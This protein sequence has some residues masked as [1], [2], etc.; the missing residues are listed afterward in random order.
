MTSTLISW[1]GITDMLAANSEEDVGLGPI[2]QAILAGEY[3]RV[4][5]LHDHG[6]SQVAE[7]LAWLEPQSA[8]KVTAHQAPLTRPT[9]YGEIYEAA[10]ALLVGLQAESGSL[11]YS[12]HLSPGTPAMGAVWLLLAKTA[13][14]GTLLESSREGGVLE[15]DVPFDIAADFIPSLLKEPDRHLARLLEGLPPEA[16]EFEQIIHRSE[17]MK[18]VLTK[19]RAVAPR[20]LP[21]LIEGESGTGKELL[22]RAIHYSSQRKDGSFVPVNCGAIPDELAESELFGHE[23]GAFTGAVKTREGA[24]QLANGGTLFLDEIGELPMQT[25]VKLLRVLQEGEIVPVGATLPIKVDV[26]IIAATNR[27]LAEEIHDGRFREDLFYRL[28]GAVLKLPPLRE[29]PGDIGL[30]LDA[31][32]VQVNEESK[33]DPGYHR[34]EL[35]AGARNFAL[36]Q[37]WP[38]NVRELLNTLRRAAVWSGGGTIETEDLR[39]ALLPMGQR[40]ESDILERPLGE[41]LSLQNL[42]EEVAQHYLGRALN[43]SAGNKTKAAELVGLPSYQTFS[44]WLKKYEVEA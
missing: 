13:F 35:S 42:L 11:V 22:S 33:E 34:K 21:V 25:Q 10:H 5:L 2:A 4:E 14:P 39:E 43:E 30:L 9:A 24:F 23:Q 28:A 16:P 19:A 36:S 20:S 44:N 6:S 3:E 7:F 8:A 26:R 12:F 27:T 1:I 31:L 18:R 41:G 32:M 29:R 40:A 38:G 37:P 17:A 15:A